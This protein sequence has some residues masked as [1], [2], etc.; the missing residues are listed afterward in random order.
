MSGWAP[1]AAPP[2]GATYQPSYMRPPK[3]ELHP[4]V[5][6]NGDVPCFVCHPTQEAE[7]TH[8]YPESIVPDPKM[9][10]RPGVNRCA[11]LSSPDNDNAVCGRP[12]SDHTV[13]GFAICTECYE[14]VRAL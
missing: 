7:G 10:I 12:G 4:G 6:W 9:F 1:H 11:V 3:C 13:L 8:E 14:A 5:G 2:P